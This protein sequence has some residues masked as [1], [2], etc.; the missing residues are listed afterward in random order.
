MWQYQHSDSQ[1]KAAS[2]KSNSQAH[3]F[4]I[5]CNISRLP[6]AC[7]QQY[8][9]PHQGL[10]TLGGY[11]LTIIIINIVKTKLL[12]HSDCSLRINRQKLNCLKIHIC[13]LL[14][15]WPTLVTFLDSL[16]EQSESREATSAAVTFPKTSDSS[17]IL[18]YSDKTL[19][20]NKHNHF[21]QASKATFSFF[22]NVI[23][24][25]KH[26]KKHWQST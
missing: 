17:A 13:N 18:V 9:K 24:Y 8:C 23:L 10:H 26:S 25:M 11:L 14:T 21:P 4:S 2:S 19:F 12:V 20:L 1:S 6:R 15:M 7:S 5:N 3:S 22:G 16:R